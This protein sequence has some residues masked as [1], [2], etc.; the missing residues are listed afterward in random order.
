MNTRRKQASRVIHPKSLLIRTFLRWKSILLCTIAACIAAG[1]Y[2][3]RKEAKQISTSP[4]EQSTS[5]NND[6]NKFI[7]AFDDAIADRY[8]YLNNTVVKDMNPYEQPVASAILFVKD[9][10]DEVFIQSEIENIDASG[11]PTAIENEVTNMKSDT[12]LSSIYNYVLNGMTWDGIREE[13]GITSN[14]LVDELVQANIENG[15]LVIKSYHSSLEG[16]EKLLAYVLDQ[17]NTKYEDLVEMTG[18]ENME[19]IV[20]DQSADIKIYSNNFAWLTNRVNEINALVDAKAKFINTYSTQVAAI[21]NSAKTTINKKYVLKTAIKGGIAG[22]GLSVFAIVIYLVFSWKVLSSKELAGN[23]DTVILSVLSPK[24][25]KKE[26]NG[27]NRIIIN[28]GDDK[29]SGLTDSVRL[30]LANSMIEKIHESD[31]KIAVISDL[32]TEKMTEITNS[33]NNAAGWSKYYALTK[34]MDQLD[35]RK[36]FSMAKGVILLAG[37]EE[38]S[39]PAIDGLLELVDN[40]KVSFIGTIV[41]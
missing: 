17:I 11:N 23:Y 40:Y 4:S 20:L 1:A 38:S 35:D 39:Y 28:F 27:L 32:E 3:Y 25:K 41:C 7:K 18:Y 21:N 33:L 29:I 37:V 15:L 5:T 12:L 26:V 30:E 22:F 9:N 36:K 14:V 8:E 16:A 6:Y 24:Y 34:V 19:L 31:E 2:A 10:N 13:L